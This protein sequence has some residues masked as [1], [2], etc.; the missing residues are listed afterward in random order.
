M[1]STY[2]AHKL[3]DH[4]FGKTTYT[5]PTTLYIALFTTMPDA[6]GVGGV[7]V[8]G[9]SY[10]RVA[11]TNDT[12]NWPNA[13]L[14]QKKNGA[15]LTFVQA[16]A[17]WGDVVGAGIYDALSSGNLLV[18]GE[19]DTPITVLTNGMVSFSVNQF[20]ATIV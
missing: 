17:D 14:R 9:G 7:E 20:I 15:D 8:S 10:A 12:T 6:D 2:L 3:L 5:G 19:F 18:F 4:V 11:S 1:I 13:S 16:S